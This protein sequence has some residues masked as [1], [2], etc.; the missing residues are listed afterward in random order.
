MAATY[1]VTVT[2][3]G[4]DGVEISSQIVEIDPSDDE[5]SLAKKLKQAAKDAALDAIG[6]S[7]HIDSGLASIPDLG[8][9]TF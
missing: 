2:I 1:H 8:G 4:P 5:V 9:F 7:L 6:A 3:E